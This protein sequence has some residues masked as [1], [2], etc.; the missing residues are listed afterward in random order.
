MIQTVRVSYS[1]SLVAP[2]IRSIGWLGYR[3]ESKSTATRPTH[4]STARV[5]ASHQGSARPRGLSWF[6]FYQRNYFLRC[7]MNVRNCFAQIYSSC[8][9]E[10]E[11]LMSEPAWASIHHL[12]STNFWYFR[13][14]IICLIWIFKLVL[15]DFYVLLSFVEAFVCIF[16]FGALENQVTFLEI[17]IKNKLVLKLLDLEKVECQNGLEV[18][19]LDFKYL[20]WYYPMLK[21][22]ACCRWLYSPIGKRLFCRLDLFCFPIF[23]Y[24]ILLMAIT[25][26]VIRPKF[27]ERIQIIDKIGD[28]ISKWN[29][30]AFSFILLYTRLIW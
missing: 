16:I 11:A 24:S 9:V 23:L 7:G 26:S 20:I 18:H 8:D 1:C 10:M 27:A 12:S 21:D 14:W 13:W 4:I 19:R 22:F 6:L 25:L 30:N 29:M 15:K 17:I 5:S 2:T 3:A 28:N